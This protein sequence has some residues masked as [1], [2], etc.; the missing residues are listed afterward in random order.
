MRN[1]LYII[2]YCPTLS[3]DI[4]HLLIHKMTLIDVSVCVCACVC[5]CVCVCVHVCVCVCVCVRVCVCVCE[6]WPNTK[7]AI[8]HLVAR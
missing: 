4:I 8:S 3:D 2:S 7:P 1:C 5:V 6:A